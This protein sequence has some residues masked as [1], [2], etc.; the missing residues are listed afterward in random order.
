MLE[1]Q[2][3]GA[4]RSGRFAGCP[5]RTQFPAM[6]FAVCLALLLLACGEAR[7]STDPA[8]VAPPGAGSEAD[9]G[10]SSNGNANGDASSDAGSNAA[11][12]S[13]GGASDAGTTDAG[14]TDGGIVD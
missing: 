2:R 7:R 10:T 11:G 8:S 3:L 4:S 13:D 12:S 14:N 9:A 1:G 6:R 5:L